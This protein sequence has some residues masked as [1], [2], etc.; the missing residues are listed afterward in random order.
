MD[1]Q[2]PIVKKS[3]TAEPPKEKLEI[4]AVVAPDQVI[5]R[6]PSLG[7]RFRNVFLGG[8]FKSAARYVG[9]VVIL[10][11]IR[12]LVFDSGSEALRRVIFPETE[13]QMRRDARGP[14]YSPKINYQRPQMLQDPRG[15]SPRHVN[16]VD[17]PRL[18]EVILVQRAEAESVV[19][20]LIDLVD[21]YNFASVADLWDLLGQPSTYVDNSWGWTNLSNITIKQIREGYLIEFPE[22]E[23][24]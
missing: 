10:P 1:E 2:S 9:A 14:N 5:R 13:R 11:A 7:S 22:L 17:R 24:K 8:D 23:A 19:E 15:V 16:P 3:K 18:D 12:N 4:E 21:K 20:A 6:K